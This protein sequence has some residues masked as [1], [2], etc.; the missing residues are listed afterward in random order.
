MTPAPNPQA[1]DA[2]QKAQAAFQQG[3]RTAARDWAAEAA[4]LEPGME[5]PWLILA[6]VASP[7]ASI[8]YLQ[9]ALQINPSSPQARQGMEWAAR[10][11][12]QT[13]TTPLAPPLKPIAVKKVSDTQPFK[14][15]PLV[16]EPTVGDT[17]PVRVTKSIPPITPAK[18]GSKALLFIPALIVTLIC[19]AAVV[20]LTLPQFTA[21]ANP[22]SAS[23]PKDLLEKPT[24]TP[25]ATAT[26]TPT[27][28]PTSTPTP[29]E[30][31]TP[32]P[33]ETPI[34]IPTYNPCPPPYCGRDSTYE[35][36]GAANPGR[37]IEVDLSTQMTY[38]YEGDAQVN[39]FL[40]SSGLWQHPTVTGQFQIYAKYPSTLMA[41]EDYYL[42][43]VPWVMYF[44]KG[45][46]FHGTYWHSNFGTPMSHGC[47]NMYT[48][49]AEW[50][51]NWADIGTTVVVHD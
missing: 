25:T 45:Y 15:A 27:S 4:R 51:Y 11:L 38:A 29:T 21:R 35:A 10:R 2:L 31:P 24:L 28:T 32:V 19:V 20:F 49:D 36:S 34:P 33:T 7:Q 23:R 26:F 8:A 40:I 42:P 30:T 9:R 12:N 50:L 6:A 3:D 43:G 16:I 18:T 22:S 46:S 17:Q 5:E 37:W 44:Y 39:S 14:T 47:L 13:G 48:P 1:L 41:G